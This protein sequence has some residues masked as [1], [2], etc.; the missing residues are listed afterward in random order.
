MQFVRE[1]LEKKGH[2]F[3]SI[4]PGAPMCD[5]VKMM[6]NQGVGSVLVIDNEDLKGLITERDCAR[7]V[8]ADCNA[9][10][11][12]PV[13]QVMSTPVLCVRPD[14]TIHECM[15]LMTDKRVRHLPV[16]TDSKVIGIVSIG[17][18]VKAVI[19]EQQFIIEQLEHY[20]AG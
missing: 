12:T 8:A 5:A 18:L 4:R 19:S 13:E 16:V 15:A 9:S 1:I 3:L 14:Q 17:D 7:R 11:D 20:I 2:D 6:A 10:P